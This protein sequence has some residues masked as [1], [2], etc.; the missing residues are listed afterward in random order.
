MLA[1]IVLDVC[2]TDLKF[3]HGDSRACRVSPHDSASQSGRRS[4]AS[5][6]SSVGRRRAEITARRAALQA[7]ATIDEQRRQLKLQQLTL[8]Q[9]RERLETEAELAALA[10]EDEVLA[11]W[12]YC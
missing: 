6:S 11:S 10:A 9:H 12:Q 3:R 7:R 8:Q 2:S 5:S 1:R 4:H